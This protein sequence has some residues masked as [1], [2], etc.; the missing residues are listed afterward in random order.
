MSLGSIITKLRCCCLVSSVLDCPDHV[1]LRR[2]LFSRFFRRFSAS[3]VEKLAKT[4]SDS[5]LEQTKGNMIYVCGAMYHVWGVPAF[6]DVF[7]EAFAERGLQMSK[8]QR[9]ENIF[10][11]CINDILLN[12]TRNWFVIAIAH[13]DEILLAHTIICLAMQ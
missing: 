4:K 8:N 6:S 10:K 11:T 2:R 12:Y 5:P 1:E 13:R 7:P 3:L 9:V